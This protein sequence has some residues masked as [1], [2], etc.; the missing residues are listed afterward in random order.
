MGVPVFNAKKEWSD[1]KDAVNLPLQEAVANHH[2]TDAVF[3]MARS[4]TPKPD[5]ALK[6]PPMASI[7]GGVVADDV[8]EWAASYNLAVKRHVG[9]RLPAILSIDGAGAYLIA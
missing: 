3:G 8:R 6:I 5:M 7:E 4:T 1:C 2:L 9:G